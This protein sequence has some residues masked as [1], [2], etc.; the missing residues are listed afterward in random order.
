MNTSQLHL[1]FQCVDTEYSTA[2]KPF[3]SENARLFSRNGIAAR[4]KLRA[5][6]RSLR[7]GLGK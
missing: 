5:F 4:N 7:V 6:S 2:G 3:L 1:P